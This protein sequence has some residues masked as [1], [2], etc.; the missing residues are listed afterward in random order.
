MEVDR[1]LFPCS[2]G[3]AEPE[4][5]IIPFIAAATAA[6]SGHRAAVVCTV[7]A[8]WIGTHGHAT[9]IEADGMP[10]LDDLVGQLVDNGGEI[11]LCSSCVTR[12]G[13]DE[14]D[15]RD[16]A[17]IVGAATLVDALANGKAITLA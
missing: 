1:L 13:I 16:G 8:V 12:R 7:D 15:L 5:A 4:R 11:W 2:H 6:V 17:Q 3:A 14:P 9:T 10:R